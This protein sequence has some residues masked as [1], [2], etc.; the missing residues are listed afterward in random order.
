M[1]A[2]VAHPVDRRSHIPTESLPSFR[3]SPPWAS[4]CSAAHETAMRAYGYGYGAWCVSQSDLRLLGSRTNLGD[5]THDPTLVTRVHDPI[6]R[7]MGADYVI[8]GHRVAAS[9]MWGWRLVGSRM[10]APPSWFG[11]RRFGEFKVHFCRHLRAVWTLCGSTGR[12]LTPR[13]HQGRHVDRR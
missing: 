6:R 13:R 11:A 7:L 5:Y 2:T 9:D 4:T 8:R 3:P 1:I 10:W 12:F